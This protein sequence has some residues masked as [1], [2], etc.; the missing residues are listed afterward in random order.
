[1]K[2][3][4][5]KYILL[6]FYLL[7]FLSFNNNWSNFKY[8]G[9]LILIIFYYLRVFRRDKINR[10][11]IGINRK[12]IILYFELF[13]F[14]VY[15]LI[16]LRYSYFY[17]NCLVKF[18]SI[19]V[20]FYFS[21]KIYYFF[22]KKVSIAT[23]NNIF[24]L[25]LTII[26]IISYIFYPNRYTDGSFGIRYY[27][28]FGYPNTLGLFCF[29]AFLL[30]IYNLDFKYINKISSKVLML[31]CDSL[32]VI[33]LIKTKC[34]TGIIMLL[35]FMIIYLFFKVINKIKNKILLLLCYIMI[36]GIVTLSLYLLTF[37]LSYEQINT[38]T[39][40]RMYMANDIINFL[41]ENNRLLLGIGGFSIMN[42]SNSVS[43]LYSDS[44]YI[45]LLY[46]Y[47][48]VG[49]I[50]LTLFLVSILLK[51]WK[52]KEQDK[53]TFILLFAV[54]FLIYNISE[55]DLINV[56]SIYGIIFYTYS[57]LFIKSNHKHNCK[58]DEKQVLIN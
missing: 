14:G 19:L 52:V 50:I 49:I 3:N 6:I 16:N 56:G 37:N 22:I 48:I 7:Y 55:N 27:G 4:F 23:N 29:L 47:G 25:A 15:L 44:S 39:S 9:M 43:I 5:E 38:V 17:I 24:I 33:T 40:N 12:C 30:S 21:L 46:Q 36:F 31:I 42:T 20:L 13:V 34:R 54:T 2:A 53:R 32:F 58:K 57:F 51:L 8:I 28:I 11:K 45:F 35:F 18:L 10:M 26:I 1:M 41:K